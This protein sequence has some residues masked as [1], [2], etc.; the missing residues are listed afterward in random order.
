MIPR[1]LYHIWLSDQPESELAH[2]CVATWHQLGME[3]REINLANCD[4]SELFV[5]QALDCG[6]IEGRVKANDFLRVLYL[7]RYG[8]FYMDNDVEVL[9]PFSPELLEADCFLG[10]EDDQLVN[11]AVIGSKAGNW[12]LG[13]CLRR[14]RLLRGDG[15][16][17]PVSVSLGIVTQILR[18]HGWPGN[19]D[20][21]VRGVCV[22]PSAAFYPI[23]WT[24]RTGETSGA[25]TIHH[26]S[27]SWNDLVTVVIPCYNYGHYL[28]EAIESALQQT[29]RN[30][31]VIVVDD[32]SSDDTRDVVARYP[33]VHYIYQ[34]NRGLSAARNTGIRAARGKYIQPLDA[35]DRLDPTSIEKSVKLMDA[36]A[37]VVCPGQKE[38]GEG[39]RFYTRDTKKFSLAHFLE[40]NRIHCASMF[41]KKAWAD[42][43]GYDERMD[44]GYE[45]WDFW[46]R[47]LAAG[48]VDIRAINEPLFFYRLHGGSMLRGMKH[49]HAEVVAG[50]RDKYRRMGICEGIPALV[51]A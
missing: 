14:M 32:G 48:Y 20:F 8:G 25:F 34:E 45:D 13:E 9:R 1:R 21:E 10:A 15:P 16:E 26:W 40:H 18:E 46:I 2:R 43:G 29:Y 50:M 47:M 39:S 27:Q 24:K 17:S 5:R 37:D 44:V 23:H 51:V 28:A 3:V 42:V 31:Q 6:T 35:D 33:T 49:K 4:R 38:F 36:G 7:F 11:M 41:R 19:L 22:L 12:L 30:V